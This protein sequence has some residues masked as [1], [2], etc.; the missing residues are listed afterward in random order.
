MATDF[1]ITSN[2]KQWQKSLSTLGKK[3]LP[4]A[5]ANT[6]NDVLFKDVKPQITNTTFPKAFKTRAKNMARGVMRIKKAKKNK[7]VGEYSDV[8]GRTYLQDQHVDAKTKTPRTGKFIAVPVFKPGRRV[9]KRK[10]KGE[11]SPR[12]LLADKSRFFL[13][14]AGR[15]STQSTAEGGSGV[16]GIWE[17]VKGGKLRMWYRMIPRAE[18]DKRLNFYEDANAVTLKNFQR[19]FEKQLLRAVKSAR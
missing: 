11:H 5:V 1:N 13:G 10:R 3:Q 8:L 16:L 19:R 14:R 17:R 12:S 9:S 6:I 4:F 2:V 15:G 7:L 18:Y